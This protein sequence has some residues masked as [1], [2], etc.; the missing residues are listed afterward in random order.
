M[1]GVN[2]RWVTFWYLGYVDMVNKGEDRDK[3]K[4]NKIW[5][6]K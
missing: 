5:S 4:N 1:I 6:D 3:I 2:G